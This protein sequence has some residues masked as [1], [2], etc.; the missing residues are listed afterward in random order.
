MSQTTKPQQGP[1]TSPA[2]K[3][4]TGLRAGPINNLR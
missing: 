4:K 1:K 2:L 3:Q